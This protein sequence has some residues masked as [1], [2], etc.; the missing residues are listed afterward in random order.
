MQLLPVLYSTGGEK[1]KKREP[2]PPTYEMCQQPLT[3]MHILLTCTN[4]ETQRWKIL[5]NLYKLHIPV[6]PRLVLG[7][8]P[9]VPL[10]DVLKFLAD[11]GFLCKLPI[12]TAF[13]VFKFD[14]R[15]PCVWRSITLIAFAPLNRIWLTIYSEKMCVLYE[16]FNPWRCH[17][18]LWERAC[19]THRK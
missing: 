18:Y 7:D 16:V 5:H 4:I 9:L 19:S 10:S 14:F 2:P 15:T 1:K 8:D 3:V 17:P 11:A 6:H 13:T 12:N